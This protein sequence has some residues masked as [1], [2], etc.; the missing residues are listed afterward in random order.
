MIWLRGE[1]LCEE[2]FYLSS[3]GNRVGCA[4]IQGARTRRGG[5]PIVARWQQEVVVGDKDRAVGEPGELVLLQKELG[6]A[7]QGGSTI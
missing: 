5:L 1:N 6:A 3:G 4:D 2:G 7:V